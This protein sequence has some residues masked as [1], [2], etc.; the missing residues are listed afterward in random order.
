MNI[1][2]E[3]YV[4]GTRVR[5]CV[6]DAPMSALRDLVDAFVRS[7]DAVSACQE[8]PTEL[9]EAALKASILNMYSAPAEQVGEDIDLAG[10]HSAYVDGLE[11]QQKQFNAAVDASVIAGLG[12][13]V[14]PQ[15]RKRRTKAEMQAA[16]AEQVPSE[17]TASVEDEPDLPL[18]DED[19]SHLV[20]NHLVG[21]NSGADEPQVT[22]TELQRFCGRLAQHFGGAQK[23]FD[24]S[25]G[26]VP[27]GAV[28]RPTNIKDNSQ[29]W[30]FIRHV[31][32]ESGLVY[33]G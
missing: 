1:K 33:H 25:A 28:A 17:P 20:E 6:E 7:C 10:N 23:V 3:E 18:A 31:E 16:R 15:K 14:E 5:V 21:D 9:F 30:A 26:F 13:A 32:K 4:R 8:Q 27:E 12:G 11:A 24:L 19:D 22:D 2:L 29:R